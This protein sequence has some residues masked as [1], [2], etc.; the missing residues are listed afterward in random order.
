M[1]LTS[2][3]SAALAAFTDAVGKTFDKSGPAPKKAK[4]GAAVAHAAAAV[5]TEVASNALIKSATVTFAANAS[6][7]DAAAPAGSVVGKPVVAVLDGSNDNGTSLY[8]KKAQIKAGPN[9]EVV[10]DQAPGVGKTP[11]V[12]VIIDNR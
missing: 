5:Q 10:L 9:L 11:K 2:A 4:I 8:V 6:T 3:Q 1:A 7:Y 12:H